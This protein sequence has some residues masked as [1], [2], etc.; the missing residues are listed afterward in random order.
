MGRNQ[1]ERIR[2]EQRQT[3][4][5]KRYLQGSPQAEIARELEVS[6]ATISSDLK[7]IRKEWKA[8]R[9]A[10]LEELLLEE[11]Q[12]LKQVFRDASQGWEQSQQPVETTKISQSPLGKTVEKSIRQQHGDPR[13]LQTMQRLI[14]QMVRL[15][16]LDETGKKLYSDQASKPVIDWGA[17]WQA[18][19]A[20]D[21]VEQKLLEVERQAAAKKSQADRSDPPSTAEDEDPPTE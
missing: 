18:C 5:S 12:R 8:Q 1:Q 17:F 9:G 7:A 16:G 21:P 10:D 19:A 3:R 15:F 11:F 13:F 6:Q 2:I 20:P 14:E 4:V